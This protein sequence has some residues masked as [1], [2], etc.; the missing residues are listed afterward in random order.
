MKLYITSP[1]RPPASAKAQV[2]GWVIEPQ[3]GV[4]I[5]VLALL[6]QQEALL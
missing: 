6:Q 5:T 3:A 1:G 2:N 4:S